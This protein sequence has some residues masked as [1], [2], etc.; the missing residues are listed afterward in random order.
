MLLN[1][2]LTQLVAELRAE[3]AKQVISEN[4]LAAM[5]ADVFGKGIATGLLSAADRIDSLIER[6][7]W[8]KEVPKDVGHWWTRI[9]DDNRIYEPYV[10][11]VEADGTDPLYFIDLDGDS[12][13]IEGHMKDRQFYSIPLT[14]PPS[15][16]II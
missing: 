6:G 4:T 9:V 7:K 8:S 5:V 2:K 1:E 15:T 3:A 13:E 11:E 16:E 14:S 10:V 12:V